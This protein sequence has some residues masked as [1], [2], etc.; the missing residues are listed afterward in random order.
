MQVTNV[1]PAMQGRTRSGEK[2]AWSLFFMALPLMALVVL[3][4]Y[5]PLFGWVLSLFEYKPGTPLFKNTYVGLKY[6]QMFFTSKDTIRVLVNTFVFSG[7][8][9]CAL[10][11]PLLMAVLLN[12]IGSARFRKLSQTM[13]T[14]PHFISWI[15]VYSIAFNHDRLGKGITGIRKVGNIHEKISNGDHWRGQYLPERACTRV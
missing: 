7:I 10:I 14:L 1:K 2:K 13:T 11:L 5:I 8:S 15:I 6:F 4:R 12:E 3:F 9:F